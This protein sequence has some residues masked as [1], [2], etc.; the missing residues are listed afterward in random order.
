MPTVPRGPEIRWLS[1]GSTCPK[2]KAGYMQPCLKGGVERAAGPHS[3]RV[4]LI[5]MPAHGSAAARQ[6]GAAAKALRSIC[7]NSTPE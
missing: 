4:R 2:C 5:R 1:L 7:L 3:Q 6:R